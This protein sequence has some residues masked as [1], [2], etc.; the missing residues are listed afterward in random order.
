MRFILLLPN[1]DIHRNKKGCN[2]KILPGLLQI[3]WRQSLPATALGA[4][5]LA[6]YLL[7]HQ[8]VME[9][10][11]QLPLFLVGLQ[12]LFLAW[13]LGR[14][15]T[16]AFAFLYSRGYSRDQLWGH[17]M[18]ASAISALAAWVSAALIVW[19]GLRSYLFN[20]FENPYFPV[21]APLETIVPLAWLVFYFTLIPIFHYV[22]IRLAQPTRGRSGGMIAAAA[23]L[24][25]F[26]MSFEVA[27]TPYLN[28][29]Y[30]WLAGLTFATTILC[31]L[32]G[33]RTL[34]RLLEVRA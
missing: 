25:A 33:S 26:A 1:I 12:C 24:V 27:R 23:L 9:W 31:T 14:F 15:N 30:A 3:Y 4:L 2:M 19:T 10:H 6:I 20:F 18:L 29:W 8:D 16:S 17:M 7:F 13:L 21:M 32:H 22:W 5:S 28:E 34:H 11:D